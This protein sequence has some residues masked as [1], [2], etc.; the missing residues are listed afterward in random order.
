M[1]EEP[2]S[3]PSLYALAVLALVTLSRTCYVLQ[4]NSI[5]YA[6][7]FQGT[8]LA[9]NNPVYMLSEAFPTLASYYAIVASV[10]FSVAYSCSNIYMG[11][12]SKKW[13]KKVM[14]CAGVLGFSATTLC[15]GLTNSLLVFAA[16]RFMFGICA[17]AINAPI[18]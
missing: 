2:S 16:C 6:Y 11:N 12:A 13:N 1:I 17:S 4:K 3:R 10:M 9:A 7:G 5:G 18:Y 14:L 8:G 15:A